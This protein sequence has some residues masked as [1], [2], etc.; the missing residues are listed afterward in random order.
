LEINNYNFTFTWA[1]AHVG[2]GGNDRVD[3]LA[4]EA[5][6]SALESNFHPFHN[7]YYPLMKS[8]LMNLWQTKWNMSDLGRYTYTQNNVQPH[9]RQIT[10]P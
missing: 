9:M 6:L 4:K 5:I 2:V 10:F 7:D 3:L 1:P 8:L